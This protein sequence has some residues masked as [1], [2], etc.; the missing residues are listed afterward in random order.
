[1]TLM[2]RIKGSDKSFEI[3]DELRKECDLLC[4]FVNWDVLEV[5]FCEQCINKMMYFYNITKHVDEVIKQE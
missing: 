4:T 1:M 3:E 5:D 2:I